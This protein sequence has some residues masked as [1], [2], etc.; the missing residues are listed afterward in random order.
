[1]AGTGFAIPAA[2]SGL[3]EIRIGCSRIHVSD[4]HAHSTGPNR[5]RASHQRL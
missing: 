3:A 4:R 1:V 5:N 2:A